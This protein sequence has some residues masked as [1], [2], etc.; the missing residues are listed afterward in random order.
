M[1][2]TRSYW[3]LLISILCSLNP[4]FAQEVVTGKVTAAENGDPLI[5]ANVLIKGTSQGTI[6]DIDGKYALSIPASV[7]EPTLIFSYIG[8]VNQEEPINQRSTVNIELAEDAKSLD[9]V[10]ITAFGVA[11]EKKA[12]NYSVQEVKSEEILETNQDNV[13]NALQGKI[14]GVQITN[15]SGSPGASSHILI[16]GANSINETTSNQPLFVVDGIPVS[17]TAAFGGSN[18]ALDINPN[19]IESVTVLKG[20]AAAALYGLEAGNGAIVITTKSGKAG[21]ARINFSSSFSADQAFQTSPRQMLYKQGNNGVFDNETT[22]SWGPLIAPGEAV[23][24]N[25]DNFL[26]IGIR[27]KYDLSI[28]SGT[29]K[30]SAYV[31]GNFL[32]HD[33][34]FPG[35]N[36]R[37]YGV[38]LKGTTAFRKNLTVN[39]SLNFVNSSNR[40]SGFGTMFNVYRWPINDDMSNFLNP[41]GSKR[42]LIPREESQIWNNPE[43]MYW[44][45]ENNPITDDVNR[46]IYNTSLSW[47]IFEPL[48]FTYRL[49]GDF[50][51]QHYKSIT[52]P[53][54]AGSAVAFSGRIS[55]V[56]RFANLITSTA[57]L[58][59]N[60]QISD[61][62]SISALLGQNI[63]ID[64][65]RNT[66]I[67]GE[68]YRNPLLDNINNLQTTQVSQN[69]SRRRIAGVFGDVKVDFNGLVFLGVTARNDW[70]STLAKEDNSFFYPSFSGGFVFSELLDANQLLTF[71][72]LRASWA[73]IGKDA[74]AHRTTAVLENFNAINGGFKYDFYAGNPNIKPEITTTWEIGAD[75]RFFNGDLRLDLSYYDML[76]DDAIIQSRISPASGWIQLVFNSGSIQN[77]GVEIVADYK[78]MKQRDFNWNVLLNVS[79]N[80]S[81]LKQLPSFVSKLPVTSGQVISAAIPSSLIGQPLMALEGTDYLYN[82]NGQLVVDENGFPRIGRYSTDNEG[83]YILNNDGMRVI[84]GSRVYLGNR[85]PDAIIGLTNSFD[86][87]NFNLSFMFDFRVGGD[88]LNAAKAA[89]IVNG[90]A[91]YLEEHRNKKMVFEGVVEQEGE[92]FVENT[93][94]VVLNQGFFINYAGVGS[95][96]VEDASWSRLRYVTL[97]YTMPQNIADR[98]GMNNLS[99]AA[100]ARNLLLLTKYSGAD[101]ETNFNGSGVGGVGNVGLDYFNV[102]TTQGIDLTLRANF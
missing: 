40:R 85:E 87:K 36:L 75:L 16:R 37:R 96:F 76:T 55:E 18:R 32:N 50:T 59:Y 22:N 69:I 66:S 81:R 49:G 102:P 26:D 98:L 60:S 24:D 100:T 28:S 79:G 29:D 54:S 82:E 93:Q 72:K 2:H 56:E 91:G 19:D 73:Q 27:Q 46:V 80:R 33:G 12:V 77:R 78:L 39:A 86:Y 97:S 92:N 83:N 53:G 99:V 10:I 15:T 42:W 71:G 43:N 7:S 51:D 5:G 14:A 20:G 17:N 11:K 9:E 38:L 44:R 65:G 41:D 1:P 13:V 57:L 101:P 95:N 25:V 52:R 35:E 74:P 84:D 63:Q 88:V 3:I 23:Y 61:K 34:I 90:S 68:N 6:T 31:S 4:A 47:N 67:S 8:Y 89:M 58:E 48:T 70:S 45:A 64:N 62:I 30:S 21:T 94:D